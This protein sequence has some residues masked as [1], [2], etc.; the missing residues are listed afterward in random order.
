M[1]GETLVAGAKVGSRAER[2]RAHQHPAIRPPQHDL[3][4][5][6][7]AAD[8]EELEGRDGLLRHDVVGHAESARQPGAVT[9]VPIEQLDD[10]GGLARGAKPLLDAVAVQRVDRPHLSAGD[11]GMRA[12]LHELVR[13]PAEAAVELVAAA[14]PQRFHIDDQRSKPGKSRLRAT[15]SSASTSNRMR[16]NST[17]SPVLTM[18]YSLQGSNGMGSSGSL[19]S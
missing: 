9:G 19:C 17:A 6:A 8:G 18:A 14:E 16:R 11:E 4:P 1:D 2:V 13:D 10:P 15:S 5:P 3:F 12:A 7:A